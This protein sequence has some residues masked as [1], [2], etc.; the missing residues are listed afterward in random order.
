[1]T[2]TERKTLGMDDDGT[3]YREAFEALFRD[4]RVPSFAELLLMC[5]LEEGDLPPRDQTPLRA[6]EFD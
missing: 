5:P 3:S 6:V 2:M 1:M 4:G